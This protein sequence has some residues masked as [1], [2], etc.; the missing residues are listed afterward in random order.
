MDW[1]GAGE[2]ELLGGGALVDGDFDESA[3]A[4]DGDGV[5]RWD[6]VVAGEEG[7]G[8]AAFLAE[9]DL[10]A[11]FCELSGEV[12]DGIAEVVDMEDFAGPAF[13]SL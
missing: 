2:L 1:G 9:A 10:G 13:G 4:G 3:G 7:D 12:G 8:A 5:V 11:G 6:A